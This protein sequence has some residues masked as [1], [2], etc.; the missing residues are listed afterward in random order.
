MRSC[1]T[2]A[3]AAAVDRRNVEFDAQLSPEAAH[4]RAD[5]GQLEQILMNLV[6][7]AKDAM[8][9]G[10]KLTMQTQNIV[11]DENHRRGLTFIRPGHY[12]MLSVS[13]TGMG[14]D[15]ETR[16]ASSSPSLPRRRKARALVLASLRS[17]ASSSR[18]RIRSGAKRRRP[19]HK[20]QI[21]L[22]RV[23]G[24]AG[25]CSAVNASNLGRF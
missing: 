25:N 4:T 17:T 12:V 24:T 9:N 3:L 5:A 16:R 10:G 6:V 18:A 20:L 13:D 7:N 15:K 23:E 19:R 11:V 14:M 2:W 1:K 8:P 22:P 21:Y